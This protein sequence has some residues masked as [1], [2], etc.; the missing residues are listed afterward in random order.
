MQVFLTVN[1][2]FICRA[3]FHCLHCSESLG[4]CGSAQH[5]KKSAKMPNSV[6]DVDLNAGV[7]ASLGQLLT[8]SA[9]NLGELLKMVPSVSR[10]SHSVTETTDGPALK[11]RRISHKP[12]T[13]VADL[14][15]VSES[16]STAQTIHSFT[17]RLR[18]LSPCFAGLYYHTL[19]SLS[20]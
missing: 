8:S 7:L 13:T 19:F 14:L 9:N 15:A 5:S 11:R 17:D 1:F 16:E 18:P 10:L 6:P 20:F 2:T 4:D 12:A 3:C